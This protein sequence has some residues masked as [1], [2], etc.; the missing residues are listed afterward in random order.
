MKK[1]TKNK[2]KI[3]KSIRSSLR[4]ILAVVQYHYLLGPKEK[5]FIVLNSI[6][7]SGTTYFRLIFAN[8]LKLYY[9][10]T[11]A[12]IT[13]KEMQS[14][15]IP[16]ERDGCFFKKN[17]KYI[18]P[19]DK[20]IRN[21]KY[22]D[23][24]YGHSYKFL[25]YCQ[26]KIISLHRNPLDVIVSRYF[27]SWAY[28]AEK[29]NPYNRPGDVIDWVLDKYIEHYN[30]L[31]KLAVKKSNILRIS[32][33][34]MILN[35]YVTFITVLNWL[36]IPLNVDKV[37]QAIMFSDI[38][39]VRLEEEMNGKAIHAPEGYKGYFTRSGKIGQWKAYFNEDEFKYIVRRLEDSDIDIGEFIIE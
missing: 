26:G 8:Y 3:V 30:C 24:I 37:K 23:L 9:D 14:N 25:E 10:K 6:H 35:P 13:Y 12:L 15:I 20:V 19:N 33:E 29:E 5:N 28:R 16:N 7:K 18:E 11:Q 17:R 22:Q 21:T 27:Y 32:Y 38:K 34:M 39:N 36:N 1:K 31:K 2:S 4:N